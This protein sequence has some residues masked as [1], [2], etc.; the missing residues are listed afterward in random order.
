[1]WPFRK[2][3]RAKDA[4]ASIRWRSIHVGVEGDGVTISGLPVWQHQWRPV[5][6]SVEL[7]HP[8]H[9][10]QR[11]RYDVYEIGEPPNAVRFAA[12]ELSNGVWGFYVPA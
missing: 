5:R 11:H 9:R 1:M 8:A 3:F 7:P 2:T 12:G 4:S 6:L 10:S